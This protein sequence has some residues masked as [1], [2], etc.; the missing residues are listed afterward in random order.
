MFGIYIHGMKDS[1]SRT[2]VKGRNPFENWQVPRDGRNM[3][4]SKIYPTY[5]WVGD[6]GRTNMGSWIEAAAKKA[7]R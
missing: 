1:N 3:L 4:L 5:D 6:D 7:N 2:D